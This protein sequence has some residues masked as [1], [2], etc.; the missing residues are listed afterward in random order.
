M[1]VAKIVQNFAFGIKKLLLI[2]F[3]CKKRLIGKSNFTY[4]PSYIYKV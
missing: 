3:F 2:V 1:L 4:R